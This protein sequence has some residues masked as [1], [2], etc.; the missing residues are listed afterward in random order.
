MKKILIAEEN[1]R[2]GAVISRFL[3]RRGYDHSTASDAD[4]A[5]FIARTER[6]DLILIDGM[7]RTAD[8]RKI[9]SI[10]RENTETSIIPVVTLPA[11]QRVG[12]AGAGSGADPGCCISRRFDLWELKE[13]IDG[14]LHGGR[15]A[16]VNPLTRLPGGISIEEEARKRI[17][18]GVKFAFSY[19]D[20]DNM[21]SYNDRY[22]YD[23]G[24]RVIERTSR[25]IKEAVLAAGGKNDFIGHMGGDDFVFITSPGMAEPVCRAITR[26]FDRTVSRYYSEKD[27]RTGY[28]KVKDRR[29]NCRD[30]PT[31]RVS[32]AIVTNLQRTIGHYAKIVEIAAEIK[33][34]LKGMYGRKNSVFMR[35]R[36][37][38]FQ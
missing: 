26:K 15:I 28:L 11:D 27:R 34:Y 1:R 5:L 24:D 32:I 10:L 12:E 4:E 23:R 6:P 8:G 7:T 38:D 17:D 31:M 25:I 33:K 19:L 3:S 20:I 22:G 21:R 36:R 13:K 30:I 2:I 35:D 29:G 16:E 14:A 9:G 18:S 37:V